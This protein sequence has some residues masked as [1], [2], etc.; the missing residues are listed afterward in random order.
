MSCT[1]CSSWAWT[2]H[3]EFTTD[4]HGPAMRYRLRNQHGDLSYASLYVPVYLWPG[5]TQDEIMA[6]VQA[7]SST[8]CAK[9]P[10]A[11]DET[12]TPIPPPLSE[13]CAAVYA[14]KNEG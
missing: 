2:G 11:A 13:G 5:I 12:N 7:T 1:A 8:S 3:A 6:Q 4:E 14:S 9:V 10:G